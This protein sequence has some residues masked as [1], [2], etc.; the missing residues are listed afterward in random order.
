MTRQVGRY[1]NS[2]HF[3]YLRDFGFLA[4]DD[5]STYTMIMFS[6]FKAFGFLATVAFGFFNW[7]LN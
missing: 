4:S 2:G 1:R 7:S 5:I 3:C 6:P